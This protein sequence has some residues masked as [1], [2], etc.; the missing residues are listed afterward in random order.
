MWTNLIGLWP[1]M[2]RLACTG[3]GHN[4]LRIVSFDPQLRLTGLFDV[5]F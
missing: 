1:W 3:S 5:D 4:A 2:I